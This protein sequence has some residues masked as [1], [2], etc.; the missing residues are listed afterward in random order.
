MADNTK[1]S[2]PTASSI[3][4]WLPASRTPTL[5]TDPIYTKYS[6]S[7]ERSLNSFLEVQEW[8]DFIAFLAKVLKSIQSFS[9]YNEIPHKLVISKRL[10]QCLNPALPAGIHQKAL[11]IYDKLFS[12]IGPQ[13][14]LRDLQMWSSG[15]FPFFQ[16]AT[17]SVRPFV[18][19]IYKTH[20]FPLRSDLRPVMKSITLSLL[21]ALE[22]ENGELFDDVSSMLDHLASATSQDFFLQNLFLILI[23]SPVSR[24][25]AL[26]YL[27][28]KMPPIETQ[29]QIELFLTSNADILRSALDL[30]C[31]SLSLN[32]LAVQ[33]YSK[34]EFKVDLSRIACRLVLRKD[35][36]LNRRLYSWLL[37]PSERKD[38]QYA[39]FEAHSLALITAWMSDDMRATEAFD[40]RPF[41]I[42]LSLLDKWEIGHSLTKHIILD[43]VSSLKLHSEEG[44]DS[45]DDIQI[46]T[47][48][49]L[50]SVDVELLWSTVNTHISS[51]L[52]RQDEA[53]MKSLD[54]VPFI[55]SSISYK[56]EIH[57]Q[58]HFPLQLL[59]IL[60][61][62]VET[63]YLQTNSLLLVKAFIITEQLVNRIQIEVLN[64]SLLS[65]LRG[66]SA[67]YKQHHI[68]EMLPEYTFLFSE[69]EVD[70]SASLYEASL[71]CLMRIIS[72]WDEMLIDSACL[73]AG[74]QAVNQLIVRKA[75]QI[76][77]RKI[78]QE[79][80][81]VFFDKLLKCIEA[82]NDFEV[83]LEM[84]TC[85]LNLKNSG[86]T[87]SFTYSQWMDRQQYARILD[88]LLPF[89]GSKASNSQLQCVKI[90]QA[91]EIV[92]SQGHVS[93]ILA[94]RLNQDFKG[95]R[96]ETTE[97]CGI[98][99]KTL[100]SVHP[101]AFD[102]TV[103]VVKTLN[104]DLD[105][106]VP[107]IQLDELWSASYF[108]N[109]TAVTRSLISK[110]NCS[111]T[112]I[113][114][115]ARKALSG[116]DSVGFEVHTN[117]NQE[118][119]IYSLQILIKFSRQIGSDFW[120]QLRSAD[121]ST[122]VDTL[123]QHTVR[124]L[125]TEPHPQIAS[126]MQPGNTLLQSAASEMIGE[127]LKN[128]ALSSDSYLALVFVT[129]DFLLHHFEVADLDIQSEGV[130]LLT[131]A[132]RCYDMSNLEG[133]T[134]LGLTV[135]KLLEV[136]VL[137]ADHQP[138]LRVWIQFA[139]FLIDKYAS[140]IDGIAVNVCRLI[141]NKVEHTL[142][143]GNACSSPSKQD[144]L[145][146]MFSC[147]NAALQ[148]AE[149]DTATTKATSVS[150]SDQFEHLIK[151]SFQVL[152]DTYF[153]LQK[154]NQQCSIALTSTC[155]HTL[156][157]VFSRNPST[158]LICAVN[159]NQI[160]DCPTEA[161]VSPDVIR[162]LS[163]DSFAIVHCFVKN[164]DVKF[165]GSIKTS[166]DY[167]LLRSLEKYISSLSTEEALRAWP[168]FLPLTNEKS[169]IRTQKRLQSYTI[170][171]CLY[172]LGVTLFASKTLIDFSKLHVEFQ[173]IL[174]RSVDS[175]V[176]A[177]TGIDD[178][179][180]WAFKKALTGLDAANAT[181]TS[182]FDNQRNTINS[183]SEKNDGDDLVG[184][185]YEFLAHELLT[186]LPN[187]SLSIEVLQSISSSVAYYLISSRL[188][189]ENKRPCQVDGVCAALLVS[190][191]RLPH[192]SKSWKG[193]VS[194]AFF[195]N[196]FFDGAKSIHWNH[197]VNAL[198]SEEKGR[199]ADLVEK[200]ALA[201]TSNIFAN[202]EHESLSR[203]LNLRRLA[204]TIY[205]G[206][207][208]TYLSQ[209]PVVKEKLV[210][211]VRNNTANPMVQSEVHLC[212]RVLLLRL[213][214]DDMSSF[215]TIVNTELLKLFNNIAF[216]PTE[217]HT[218]LLPLLLSSC[219]LLDTLLVI[220][221]ED[222][223]TFQSLYVTDTVDAYHSTE[224]HGAVD[225]LSAVYR[226]VHSGT[227]E[228][229]LHPTTVSN[230]RQPMLSA[231]KKIDNIETLV[232][233]FD[234]LSEMTIKNVIKNQEI[235]WNALENAIAD[236]LFDN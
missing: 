171:R 127:V 37:G 180:P 44:M 24:I 170:L 107:S 13:G 11:E 63:R 214:D 187:F 40:S 225:S 39:Y 16:H 3:S 231:G 114:Q 27:L 111:D 124:I 93:S 68:S 84:L 67:F 206:T 126:T 69:E 166:K 205:A 213:K 195:D 117:W 141:C 233:F 142:N 173:E 230:K 45:L 220:Q 145:Q 103:P 211:V 100:S 235:D 193:I 12:V 135:V 21:P 183:L 112:N 1:D 158:V 20:Y 52:V 14:L 198:M 136:A 229:D 131:I 133:N 86:L 204:Y 19:D 65:L 9:Q 4:S 125:Q 221:K 99:Y 29:Q 25:S 160:S 23:T 77:C 109:P 32:G 34:F 167:I 104:S 215:W 152:T 129:S 79:L 120:T 184:Q 10:S 197:L 38:S 172:H 146:M 96:S 156:R 185:I 62:A 46:M 50:E 174:R 162:L 226:R 192:C 178:T 122:I 168:A 53:A 105:C 51:M 91:L 186:A 71:V 159:F 153:E 149:E 80:C 200:V 203:A 87:E 224:R 110:V 143:I 59:Q 190:L 41:K 55:I 115:V 26:N 98:A 66:K 30:L 31:S 60:R 7:I 18:L 201:P 148:I 169:S 42:Y 35:M 95:V 155:Q 150:A 181:L 90:I 70:A 137:E 154:G 194:E 212:L 54:L 113:F 119:A 57:F 43:V 165:E 108:S 33:K 78:S 6:H 236:D 83:K 5:N 216:A 227:P 89:L 8:A 76:I 47:N 49:I 208:D 182:D 132:L 234:M 217:K 88:V 177:A 161:I 94:Q 56:D 232:P 121:D 134:K 81:K 85:L 92:T 191:T 74:F 196:K 222:F 228:L 202:R 176:Q 144:D 123:L 210:E 97:Q 218:D 72:S 157:A 188:K 163:S 151:R 128:H 64:D 219:K 22:E 61:L 116:G 209:M 106:A 139:S 2:S 199:F 75:T 48:M 164:I 138:L 130:K 189:L 17:T 28:R 147:L 58:L 101:T 223:L 175:C 82:P 73:K 207:P 118:M 102:L 36:S 140:V 179:S 15:I